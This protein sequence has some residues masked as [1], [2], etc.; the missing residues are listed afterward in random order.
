[1]RA[2]GAVLAPPNP[3]LV[4]V[5][6]SRNTRHAHIKPRTRGY[7]GTS[8]GTPGLG[9]NFAVAQESAYV[10]LYIDRGDKAENKR[11]FDA[12]FSKREAIE[13]AFEKPLSWDRLEDRH[14]SRIKF[15]VAGGYRS[16]EAEWP[17][18]HDTLVTAMTK[19]DASLTPALN[20][21]DS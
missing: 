20:A 2:G 19:L 15:M 4:A 6:R 21:L 17:S 10:E 16:P 5:A 1:M 12:L 8:S 3:P 7:I 9:F 18:I 13:S 11:I 14:A